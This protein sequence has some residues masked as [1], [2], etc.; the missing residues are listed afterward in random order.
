[1]PPWRA[2]RIG[3]N[4]YGNKPADPRNW[5]KPKWLKKQGPKSKLTKLRKWNL[6]KQAKKA[7]KKVP[8]LSTRDAKAETASPEDEE[9][10]ASP[11][12]HPHYRRL[13]GK[14]VRK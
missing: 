5:D 11:P 12:R 6:K 7:M 14:T 4:A 13:L 1:M 9:E 8:P 2:D 10:Y 3:L